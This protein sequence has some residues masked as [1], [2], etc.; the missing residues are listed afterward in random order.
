MNQSIQDASMD[1]SVLSE[2]GTAAPDIHFNGFISNTTSMNDVKFSWY[3]QPAQMQRKS[4]I[5]EFDMN[6]LSKS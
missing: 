5:L 2:A 3:Q 6:R 1:K 4:S